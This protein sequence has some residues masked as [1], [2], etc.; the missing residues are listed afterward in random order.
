MLHLH[1]ID[2]VSLIVP[3]SSVLSDDVLCG[4]RG[5]TLGFLPAGAFLLIMLCLHSGH[6][7]LVF[8]QGSIHFLWNSWLHGSVL[9]VSLRLN[10]SKHTAQL[11]PSWELREVVSSSS[12]LVRSSL[13]LL[14]FLVGIWANAL[15]VALWALVCKI[16]KI[17]D[18]KDFK[19]IKVKLL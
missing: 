6:V 14:C 16:T 3:L 9:I 18:Q 4:V 10:D 17:N 7:P 11:G 2:K 8:S 12:L 5:T 19:K 13:L 15:V 1:T